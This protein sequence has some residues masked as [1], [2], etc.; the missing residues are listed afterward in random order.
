VRY[1][2]SNSYAY[3]V[4]TRAEIPAGDCPQGYS[5]AH[6]S[7]GTYS[8]VPGSAAAIKPISI[9]T[10]DISTCGVDCLVNPACLSWSIFDGT[11]GHVGNKQSQCHFYTQS[12]TDIKAGYETVHWDYTLDDTYATLFDYDCWDQNGRNC[13]PGQ[14]R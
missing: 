11:L 8:L 6:K 4:V 7:C 2:V 5:I 1:T 9:A 12:V 14:Q 3:S 13:F 10:G